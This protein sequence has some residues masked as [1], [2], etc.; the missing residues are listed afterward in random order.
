MNH[1]HLFQIRKTKHIF[2]MQMIHNLFGH[3]NIKDIKRTIDA[4]VIGS[5]RSDMIDWTGLDHVSPACRVRQEDINIFLNL[6]YNIK[7]NMVHL[8][9]FIL[10]CMV[11]L[12]TSLLPLLNI[13]LPSLMKT[14]VLDGVFHFA[15]KLKNLLFVFLRIWL[16]LLIISSARKFSVFTW[17]VVLNLP[18][19]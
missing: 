15:I 9:I 18:T 11:Q 16:N 3:L 10:T 19:L 8:N 12:I 5:L 1:S 17:T 13:L 2:T 4:K 14:L 6:V 7:K